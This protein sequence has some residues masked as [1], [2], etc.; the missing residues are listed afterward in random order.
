MGDARRWSVTYTKHVKQKRKVY[1]DGFLELQSASHK[2]VLYDDCE[3]LLDSR[4]VKMDDVVRLGETLTF[5][6]Y[7][8]DIG[9][10]EGEQKPKPKPKPNLNLQE[11]EKKI[12]EKAG[13]LHGQKFKNSLHSDVD[14]VFSVYIHIS[15]DLGASNVFLSMMSC[16]ITEFKKSEISKYGVS[17]SCPDTVKKSTAVDHSV[18]ILGVYGHSLNSKSSSELPMAMLYDA[19]G[20]ILDSRF[21]KKDETIRSGEFLKFDGHL[22]DIGECEGDHK[23]LVD[24]NL[25]GGNC[26]VVKKT[27]TMQGQ[28]VQTHTASS[29]EWEAMYTSQITQKSKK[30]HCGILRLASCGSYQKKVTLLAEDGTILSRKYLKLSEDVRTGSTLQLPSYPVEVGEQ[31]KHP[32][33]EP[34]SEGSSWEENKLNARSSDVDNITLSRRAPANKPFWCGELP[35]NA[36]YR[37][38]GINTLRALPLTTL[39]QIGEC[40]LP[41]LYVMVAVCAAHAI[42]SFLKKPAT[43]DGICGTE[44]ASVEGC[45]ASQS[46][47]VVHSHLMGR[48]VQDSS[49]KRSAVKDHDQQISTMHNSG[50]EIVR[51]ETVC[52]EILSKTSASVDFDERGDQEAKVLTS[53]S[54][55][56]GAGKSNISKSML[57]V[58][59]KGTGGSNKMPVCHIVEPQVLVDCNLNHDG[60]SGIVSVPHDGLNQDMESGSFPELLSSK[61]ASRSSVTILSKEVNPES[62]LQSGPGDIRLNI[63]LD[64]AFGFGIGTSVGCTPQDSCDGKRNYSEQISTRITDDCPTFDLG[65]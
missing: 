2:V 8:V 44:E 58:D 35:K 16:T 22:V 5:G 7:L 27:K 23:P 34:R 47:D 32:Q 60:Q 25:Q 31:R 37:T 19:T 63:T 11:R 46:S 57:D 59:V 55:A 20:A 30:Y 29:I 51:S 45:Y 21:L 38:I 24:L 56:V 50:G 33:V 12:S 17:P 41:S 62:T 15:T 1:Q 64:G 65:F 53:F 6:A 43:Q 3:K 49:S 13:S 10:P 36:L 9:D 54:F 42:M 61:V 18:L 28:Q 26:N 40:L 52:N 48:L 4:F 14:D 39:N